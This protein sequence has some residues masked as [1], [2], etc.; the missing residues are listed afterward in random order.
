MGNLAPKSQTQQ[1]IDIVNEA[2]SSAI[3]KIAQECATSAD[4]S[5]FINLIAERD[6]TISGSTFS[7]TVKVVNVECLMKTEKQAEIM[8]A[9]AQNLAQQAT[10]DNKGVGIL[11]ANTEAN[12]ETYIKTRLMSTINFETIQKNITT[13]IS[14]M[15]INAK[16]GRDITI[17]DTVFKNSIEVATKTILEDNAVAGL[18][19]DVISEAVQENKTSSGWNPLNFDIAT[20]FY[21]ILILIIVI[22]IAIM[23][24]NYIPIN[25]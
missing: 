16:S 7:Q 19:N 23:A 1:K 8:N 4:A 22:T 2:C 6:I 13:A 25:A 20:I 24:V 21:Y 9:I 5:M 10:V 11:G 12:T 17:S 3:M 14:N 15:T 18:I